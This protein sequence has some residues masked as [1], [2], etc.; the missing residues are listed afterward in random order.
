MKVRMRRLE[1]RKV[2]R[3]A[4]AAFF[5][6]SLGIL[7]A[8][9][10]GG[11][12]LFRVCED[13]GECRCS[14]SNCGEGADFDTRSNRC[15]CLRGYHLVGGQ[16]LLPQEA[17]AYCGVGQHWEARGCVTDSC[18]PGEE[19]DQG[20]GRCAPKE[21]L[22]KVAS[23]LGVSLGQGQKL[24]CPEGQKLIVD[25]ANAVCV[26]L[27][28]TCTRDETWNGKE[29][30]KVQQCP[31]GA[32]WDAA[33]GQCVAFTKGT[34]EE[35]T[36][37]VAQWAAMNFGQPNGPGTPAFCGSFSKKPYLFGIHPGSSAMLRVNVMLSFPENEVAKGT[38][39]TQAIFE[40]NGGAVP[41]KAA[42]EI[43]AS[44]KSMFATLV[45]GAGRSG[46]PVTSTLVKCAVVSA[47]KPLPVPA[48]GGL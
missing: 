5:L 31:A 43:D 34:A 27:A 22:N 19:L 1:A 28:Q 37:D 47:A 14:I 9:C 18:G 36:V 13:N 23:N 33:Q 12:C 26:P 25:G 20:T 10:A 40:H 7:A 29:C 6:V 16:C 30:V 11:T 8:G 2:V 15:R 45:K 46:A 41:P 38:V 39:Q 17:N 4:G 3:L 24:G 44:A 42:S 32:S 21:Q 35:V 48:T